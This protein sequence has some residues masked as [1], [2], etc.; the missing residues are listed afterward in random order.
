MDA[1]RGALEPIVNVTEPFVLRPDVVLVPCA[2][3]ME[4]LRDR[5]EFEEGDYT[6]SQRHGRAVARVIDGE[7]AALLALF[8]APRTIVEAVVENSRALQRDPRALLEEVLPHIAT[9]VRSGVLVAA[10]SAAAADIRP[11]YEPGTSVGDWEIVRCVSVIEDTEIYQA[12]N[13]RNTA[14][15]KIARVLTPQ[16]RAL[17]DN[18]AAILRH[19]EGSGVAPRLRRADV[20]DGWP[21]LAMDWVPGVDAGVAAVQRRYD[22][23]AMAQLCASIAAAYAA[24]HERGVLHADVHPRNVLF[25]ES[26]TLVDFGL[27]LC[28]GHP[29]HAGRGGVPFFFEPKL[30]AATRE[31]R[32]TLPSEAG[33]QYA[34]AALLYYLIAGHHYLDFRL[35]AAEMR[36]QIESEA[37]MPFA[38]R[39]LPPWPEVE[40]ILFRAL[41]KD[42]ARRFA[43]MREFAELLAGAHAAD[44]PLDTSLSD[45]AQS[46]LETT[47]RSFARGGRMFADRYAGAPKASVSLGAAGAAAGLLRIAESRGDPR[48]LALAD[49]WRMRARTAMTDDTAFYDDRELT[50]ERVGEWTPFH[51]A[52][53]VHAVAAM[54]AAAMSQ[55]STLRRALAEFVRCGPPSCASLDLTLGR[56]GSVLVAAMLRDLTGPDFTHAAELW[57]FGHLAMDGIWSELDRLP[58]IADSPPK[59]YLGMAHGW[60]GYLYAALR[61]CT[62]SGD[63]LPLS[64]DRRLHELSA[65]CTR[66]GRGGVWPIAA[67]DGPDSQLNGWCHGSAG[68]VFLFTLAHRMLREPRWLEL[69]E[70]AAWNAWDEPRHAASLCCGTAGRAYALL[71]FYKHTGQTAWVRRARQL[72]NHAAAHAVSTSQRTNTLWKGELGVAVLIADLASPENARMPFFE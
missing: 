68:Y 55:P 12:R 41:E 2:D 3:L 66:S 33:E 20:Y 26:V 49:L 37:P 21:Y 34:V 31:G 44:E 56:S 4:E 27:S 1:V 50:R 5:L 17:L 61:W 48:L 59:T 71:N 38:T 28:A 70:L 67:G 25:G 16:L 60:T 36:R 57:D 51:A 46:L 13:G 22:R 9:F 10:S 30:C 18:E 58:A 47:L 24:L 39:G 14:A 54:I 43:S 6:L 72:A 8:R 29:A 45:E 69:A 42:P 64:L 11:R 35:D 52:P 7:T 15:L 53:G 63:T 40:R 62:A 65:L 19:L 32:S 23:G